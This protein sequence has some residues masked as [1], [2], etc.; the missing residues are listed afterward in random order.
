MK[1]PES[2]AFG[3]EHDLEGVPSTLEQYAIDHCDLDVAVLW[4]CPIIEG[5]GRKF[6]VLLKGSGYASHLYRLQYPAAPNFP[7]PIK[8]GIFKGTNGISGIQ[9]LMVSYEDENTVIGRKITV[10]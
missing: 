6:K 9:F 1:C 3:R 7:V 4:N 10:L 8:P 5:L 2:V